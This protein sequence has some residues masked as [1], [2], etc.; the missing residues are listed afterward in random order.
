MMR[1]ER[2]RMTWWHRSNQ[3]LHVAL[4]SRPEDARRRRAGSSRTNT[5]VGLGQEKMA[6]P[7][8]DEDVVTLAASAARA[9]AA[10]IGDRADIE[11]LLFATES[12]IDQSKAA[13][14]FV[15]GLL[16]LPTALP[17]GGAE[18]GLLQRDR[19]RC[20]W[21][22]PG[23]SANPGKQALVMA[24]DV[25]RYDLGSP[26]RADAGLRRRGHAGRARIRAAGARSRVR[27][28]HRRRHG[29][30]AA[31]TTATKRW[32]TASIRRASI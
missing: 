20:S 28:A 30:L 27:P 6:M 18:A 13:G 12:G 17:R 31:R 14:I 24:S 1:G 22:S 10:S 15:H 21:P 11:L 4:L 25:A 8:P 9:A 32:W 29:F 26:G 19:R 2:L 5:I 16:G 3:F 7:P 23:F